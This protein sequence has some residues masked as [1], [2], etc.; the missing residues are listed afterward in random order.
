MIKYGGSNKLKKACVYV[1][2]LSHSYYKYSMYMYKVQWNLAYPNIIH[3][4]TSLIQSACL[5]YF[6]KKLVIFLLYD[7][8]DMLNR[9]R[10]LLGKAFK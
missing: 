9:S 8:T 2:Y 4:N 5:W 7:T 1:P 6:I 10:L 3:T